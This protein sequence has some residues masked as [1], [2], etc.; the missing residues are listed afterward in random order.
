MDVLKLLEIS[1]RFIITKQ[2]DGSYD[3]ESNNSDVGSSI[4][5]TGDIKY[6]LTGCYN[7]GSDWISIDVEALNELTELC[8]L[9]LKQEGK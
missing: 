1:Q 7:S 8:E 5:K 4:D 6:F 9:I 2:D 3:I